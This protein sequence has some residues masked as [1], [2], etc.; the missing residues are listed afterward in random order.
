[1]V[2]VPTPAEV[3]FSTPCYIKRSVEAIHSMLIWMLTFSC[4][5]MYEET[6]Y[7]QGVALALERELY[8][9]QRGYTP[10]WVIFYHF[11]CSTLHPMKHYLEGVL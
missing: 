11:P 3:I 4:H 8:V 5:I 1:M 6:K 9:V 2:N 7:V 10:R